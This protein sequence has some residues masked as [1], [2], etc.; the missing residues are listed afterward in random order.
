M[1]LLFA[2]SGPVMW[3]ASTHIDK[4]LVEK[5]FK[6]SSTTVLMVFTALIGLFMLPFIW[7]FVPGVFAL[8]LSSIA[9]MAASGVLGM[10]A[11]LF[12]LQALQTSE[13]SVVA[14]MFQLSVLWGAL[15]AYL[16]LGELLTGVQE[17][18][19]LLIV[20]SALLLSV[21]SSL[22]FTRDNARFVV[23]MLCATFVLALSSVIFKYFA[24]H[25]E[26]WST[27]FWVFVGEALFGAGILCVPAYW[28]Q[29]LRLMRT[30]TGATL[31][32]NSANE[33]IN[34]GGG[35]LGGARHRARTTGLGGAIVW[36][37]SPIG[38]MLAG[39]LH[40]NCYTIACLRR[41]AAPMRWCW[42]C[43]AAG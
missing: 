30:N 38:M 25:D 34:L 2:L 36:S 5:Y 19:A 37:C 12:Y 14:P 10:G 20:A 9:V 13:A 29:F 41:Q 16:L 17:L 8:P 22:R 6:N 11:M 33:L 23:L 43:R 31:G 28:R 42:R 3:A 1:W 26:Y 32:V 4:Y 39:S 15:L 18:G 7:W 35:A 21:D 24:V 40:K 27:A